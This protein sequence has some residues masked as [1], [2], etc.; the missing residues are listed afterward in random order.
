MNP[1]TYWPALFGHSVVRDANQSPGGT[2][3][4]ALAP[5]NEPQ[6]NHD[7]YPETSAICSP[8]YN[9]SRTSLDVAPDASGLPLRLGSAG[10]LPVLSG[11]TPLVDGLPPMPSAARPCGYTAADR[12]RHASE[13]AAAIEAGQRQYPSR[14]RYEYALGVVVCPRARARLCA[15]GLLAGLIVIEPTPAAH[16]D[17]LRELARLGERAPLVIGLMGA[18]SFD[19]MA[20]RIGAATLLF[21]VPEAVTARIVQSFGERAHR[22]IDKP[23]VLHV[24]AHKGL[25]S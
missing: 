15:E 1:E 6:P 10:T 22:V 23:R 5:S 25:E 11:R 16:W 2:G 20:Q 4:L 8:E 3:V 17:R 12:K 14:S 13:R 7:E 21:C 9:R 19:A 24:I 18:A